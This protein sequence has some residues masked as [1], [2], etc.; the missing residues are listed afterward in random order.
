MFP[1]KLV[2]N[3]LNNERRNCQLTLICKISPLENLLYLRKRELISSSLSNEDIFNKQVCIILTLDHLKF[4][5]LGIL[6]KYEYP[7]CIKHISIREEIANGHSYLLRI[8]YIEEKRELRKCSGSNENIFSKQVLHN[9]ILLTQVQKLGYASKKT[10][11]QC[12][13]Q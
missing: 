12:F 13:K 5:D 6:Q 1:Q 9:P 10:C 2:L 4:K 11:S 7:N 8:D 3:V